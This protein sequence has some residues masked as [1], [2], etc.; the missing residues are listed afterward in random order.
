MTPSKPRSSVVN[1]LL[2]DLIPTGTLD[3][4][5][6]TAL[7]KKLVT[8]SWADSVLTALLAKTGEHALDKDREPFDSGDEELD[9]LFVRKFVL[10]NILK[11]Y[12]EASSSTEPL[13]VKYARM[14][15][16]AELM[17]HIMMGKENVA[18]TDTP[19]ALA[20]QKQL[21]RIMFEKGF[22]SA[23]TASIADID[24]NFP[25]AKRAVKYILR[26]LKT[27]TN[28]AVSLSDLNL[29]SA[30]PGQN[31]EEEI[32]SATSISE[33]D[34]DRE[35]TPDLF[36]NST[37]GMFEPGREEDS[38]SDSDDGMLCPLH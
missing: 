7:R 2:F 14:L 35:E 22:I 10:E 33:P 21:R 26:P 18:M 6:T 32:E 4:A 31:E 20:S 24:L 28:A 19:L 25:G 15:S 38:S 13:D 17:N 1:Y 3:H 29:I 11:A 16:L 12:K 37:L 23:L 8:S 5:E 34:D 9:L 27:L 36:R 30:V